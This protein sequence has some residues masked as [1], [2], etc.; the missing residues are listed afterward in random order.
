M[1]DRRLEDADFRPGAADAASD[2]L[3]PVDAA[4]PVG[5]AP[6]PP[7]EPVDATAPGAACGPDPVPEAVW[8]P[9]EA[10][11]DSSEGC[12][13]PEVATRDRPP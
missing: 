11:P 6:D 8:P 5:A 13:G 9:D 10:V 3:P 1:A 7:P 2:P 4:E 12:P